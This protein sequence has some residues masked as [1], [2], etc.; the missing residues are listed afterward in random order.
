VKKTELSKCFEFDSF[1][2]RRLPGDPRDPCEVR[3][4]FFVRSVDMQSFFQD[5]FDN[6]RV[7]VRS[8]EP[9]SEEDF[10][11]AVTEVLQFE[12]QYRLELPAIPPSV[13]V[14]AVR[15][16]TSMFYRASQLLVFRDIDAT[17]I[18]QDLSTACPIADTPS[19][20]YSVDLTFRFIPD[21]LKQARHVSGDDPLLRWLTK[22]ANA[23]PL[24]S[25]GIPDMESL[26]IDAI[27]EDQCLLKL[28]GDRIIEQNDLS[29]LSDD[30][31]NNA[32]RAALGAYPDLAP[33]IA[34]A[35]KA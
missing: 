3:F 14:D 16:S 20:H 30:R 17:Q 6:G 31:V 29:R 19:A 27:A 13:S 22:W 1:D 5:L 35:I 33:E 2:S 25:V 4:D 26:N 10:S 9:P 32:V 34:A 24:S 28:Y 15:W 12:R 23:W 7:T 18:D 11:A 8:H 21:L